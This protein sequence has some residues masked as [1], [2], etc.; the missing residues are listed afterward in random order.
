MR[1]ILSLLLLASLFT[2]CQQNNSG[3][4]VNTNQ[5]NYEFSKKTDA[6]RIHIEHEPH[7]ARVLFTA[8]PDVQINEIN[9]FSLDTTENTP[10]QGTVDTLIAEPNDIRPWRFVYEVKTSQGD[11]HLEVEVRK[12]LRVDRKIHVKELKF[13]SNLLKLE[14]LTILS[15]GELITGGL[16]ILIETKTSFFEEGATISTY[17]DEEVQTAPPF[18]QEGRS[19][20]HIRI[21][22]K[23][24]EGIL[25]VFLK[26]SIGGQG[27]PGAPTP[28]HIIGSPGKPG[29]PGNSRR[30]RNPDG[31]ENVCVAE[32][33]DGEK[34]GKGIQG[35]KGLRGLP[36][37]D[38]GRFEF[39]TES[40]SLLTLKIAQIPGP[41]G[42]G[43][44][45]G[46]G[47][48]GGLGGP[49]GRSN[50]CSASAKS[51]PEGD[52]GDQGPQG[53]AGPTGKLGTAC[54]VSP[55]KNLCERVPDIQLELE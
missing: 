17:S 16:D 45:G 53:D 47:G 24:A 41:G 21:K 48:R 29:H 31:Y 51:G 18:K 33:G 23:Y 55:S 32:P 46:Q 40:D 49:P 19:G 35:G 1:K 7:L 13:D 36:G 27:E 28:D 50:H 37:G 43:G 38:A 54:L 15:G 8:A 2:A 42:K 11:F 39:E 44:V 5:D 30:W 3:N 4:D 25:K 52:R 34:G 22:S 9:R 14:S 20:G 26:G 6:I 10:V 12:D